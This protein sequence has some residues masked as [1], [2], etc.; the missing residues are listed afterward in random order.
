MVFTVISMGGGAPI[1][2][3]RLKFSLSRSSHSIDK[4]PMAKNECICK[5]YEVISPIM[6]P[7]HLI[8]HVYSFEIDWPPF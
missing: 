1:E 3:L 4:L 5:V 8:M 7:N 2:P 6:T